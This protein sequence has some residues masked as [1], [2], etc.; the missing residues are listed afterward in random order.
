MSDCAER[1]A[2]ETV[3]VYNKQRVAM[4]TQHG[5]ESVIG[6]VLQPV[7]GCQV[8][9]VL[10]YD[11]DRLG[12][13]TRDIA[14]AGT[15]LEAARKKARIGM[16]L[17]GLPIGLASE[18]AFGPDPFAGILPWNTEVL[19]WVDDG[20]GIE[21]IG[22]SSG[23]TNFAHRLV[24][25]RE[26]AEAFAATAG[27]PEHRLVVRPEQENHPDYSKGL[28][29]WFSFREAVDKSL[30]LAANR[31]AFIETD[32]RAFANPTRMESIRL[33]A[34]DLARKLLSLCPACAAPGFSR[35]RLVPGLLCEDC[36]MPTRE[37]KA[38][39]HRC[40]KCAYQVEVQRE[41]GYA[42]AL[43]CE[44]CNP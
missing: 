34:E 4:L 16:E 33:A 38:E 30:Q 40:V 28:G 20:L 27:F 21:V 5:K 8:E 1:N 17:T 13:F 26:E 35:A 44:Y 7:L 39:L 24:A 11:T 36:G 15:Q 23:K 6:A 3:S 2:G 12:T 9:R 18:G 19:I 10:G 14:R 41:D 22:T 42:Q 31:R 25:S 32:M 37:A 29:D 43:H